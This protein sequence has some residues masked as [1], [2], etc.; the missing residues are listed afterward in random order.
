MKSACFTGCSFTVGEGFDP[1]QRDQFIYDRLVSDRCHFRRTNLA[2]GGNSNH[3]IFM[4][5]ARAM[6]QAFDIVFV[7][8]SV[9]NRIW[10]YPGPDCEWSINVGKKEFRYR[11]IYLD[12]DRKQLF[13]DQLRMMNHDYQNIFFLIDYCHILSDLASLHGKK[14]VFINGLIPWSDDLIRPMGQDLS[15]SLS[16]YSKALLD[17]DHRDDDE[18]LKLFSA[19]RDKAATLDQSKWV[20]IW[21]SFQSMQ[22]DRGPQGHH[23][24]QKS[25]RIMAD[26]IV[27]HLVTQKIL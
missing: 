5:A 6:I 19:L 4:S 22:V 7:Q 16:F 27:E 11:E 18:I 23:P 8:W 25:H 2:K 14:L 17:F 13:Q 15:S 24:G 21:R 3:E 10:L 9:L 1:D 26:L 12:S 20:N